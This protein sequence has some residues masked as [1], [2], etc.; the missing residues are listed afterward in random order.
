MDVRAGFGGDS[1]VQLQCGWLSCRTLLNVCE[2]HPHLLLPRRW[3]CRSHA[4]DALLASVD[5]NQPALH[6]QARGA[7]LWRSGGPN[8]KKSQ[9]A[10]QMQPRRNRLWE[11]DPFRAQA[12]GKSNS[13]QQI[14]VCIVMAASWGCMAI[15]QACGFQFDISNMPQSRKYNSSK[16]IRSLRNSKI[17]PGSPVESPDFLADRLP[18]FHCTSLPH[19]DALKSPQTVRV[20]TSLKLATACVFILA[21]ACATVRFSNPCI[22][23]A[24][25]ACA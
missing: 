16:G 6:R 11:I 8:R 19:L 4:W 7:L 1:N 25:L 14:L 24:C 13:A 15:C 12:R 3:Q 5:C 17:F 22:A 23:S 2:S 18:S 9:W 10:M 21:L 20:M